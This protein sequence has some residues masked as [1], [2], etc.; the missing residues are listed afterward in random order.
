MPKTT[1]SFNPAEYAL[2]ADRISL[3]YEQYPAGRIVT[4][5]ISRDRDVVFRAA[6]YRTPDDRVP[7]ATGWASE[8]EGDGD[9]NMVA[10][11]ENTETSAIGRALANLGFTASRKRPSREEM[12]KADRAR[13]RQAHEPPAHERALRVAEM[14]A[15]VPYQTSRPAGELGTPASPPVAAPVLNSPATEAAADLRDLLDDAAAKGIPAERLSAV[16]ALLDGPL[17]EAAIVKLEEAVR[18]WLARH[19]KPGETASAEEGP[20]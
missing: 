18:G 13:Q 4:R 11:V 16:R 20:M 14:P 17:D 12:V 15:S 3:F 9:I 2:V 10:C 19:H 8:R 5:M 1:L 7:A 6:V